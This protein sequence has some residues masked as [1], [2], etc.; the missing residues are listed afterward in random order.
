MTMREKPGTRLAQQGNSTAQPHKGM[1]GDISCS[2]KGGGKHDGNFGFR[3]CGVF[4]N[5]GFD[6]L[7]F[8]SQSCVF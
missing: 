4:L 7:F 2:V 6:L 1:M 8:W 5:L 3:I